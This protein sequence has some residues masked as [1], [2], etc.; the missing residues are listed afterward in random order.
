MIVGIKGEIV[1]KEPTVL[2]IFVNG[3]TYEVKVS[4]NTSATLKEG[5]RDI[6][7]KITEII[8]ED[9]YTLYGFLTKDEKRMFDTLI[10]ING[11]GPKVALAICSTFL[12]TQFAEIISSKD[13]KS[14]KKVSGI[15]PKA[16][17]RILIELAD[18]LCQLQ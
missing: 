11:I 12:P 6:N 8:R 5:D 14:L 4:L 13:S 10:K 9:S 1:Y 16:A 7:L 3:L 18:L 17:N 15:G 2:H